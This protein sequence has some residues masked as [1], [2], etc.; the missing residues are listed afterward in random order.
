MI[1]D[2]FDMG[3]NGL[4]PGQSK[5]GATARLEGKLFGSETI[6]IEGQVKGEILV[7]GS[8]KITQ[9][10]EVNGR[11]KTDKLFL[12]GML[13]GSLDVAGSLSVE[14]TAII[15]GDIKA[16]EAEIKAGAIINGQCSIGEIVK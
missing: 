6:I 9:N 1:K 12:Y 15:Y 10:A 8:L 16:G 3:G 5:F 2:F 4:P 11:V 7:S 13:E 14:R